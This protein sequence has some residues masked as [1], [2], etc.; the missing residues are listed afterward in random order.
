MPDGWLTA[1]RDCFD[2]A[3]ADEESTTATIA[4]LERKAGLLVDPHTAV[5]M[6]AALDRSDTDRMVTLSTAHPA[7]FPDAIERAIGRQ[8]EPPPAVAALMRREER[9]AQLPN[10]LAEVQAFV[11]GRALAVA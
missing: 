2:S 10:D 11:R 6:R 7:K 8:P 4:E 5:A 1:A 9:V 3:R